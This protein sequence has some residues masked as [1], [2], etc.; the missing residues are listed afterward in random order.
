MID[1]SNNYQ[2]TLLDALNE[3]ASG[4]YYRKQDFT[5]TPTGEYSMDLQMV[6]DHYKLEMCQSID[7][8][9]GYWTITH[10]KGEHQNPGPY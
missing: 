6:N 10:V 9:G 4:D 1:D 3:C 2:P 5:L 8:W 7:Q